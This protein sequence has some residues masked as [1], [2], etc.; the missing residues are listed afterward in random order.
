MTQH[1]L[2]YNSYQVSSLCQKL[3]ETHLRPSTN[4]KYSKFSALNEMAC[5]I[6]SSTLVAWPR[7]MKAFLFY[8]LWISNINFHVTRC[9]VNLPHHIYS[10]H[11]HSSFKGCCWGQEV[12]EVGQENAWIRW[13]TQTVPGSS[14]CWIQV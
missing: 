10:L 9:S 3:R 11:I 4:N 5:H 8:C 1:K 14:Y 2:V 7:Q 6:S 12:S 13:W